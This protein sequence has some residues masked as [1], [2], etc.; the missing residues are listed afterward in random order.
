MQTENEK[1]TRRLASLL[2]LVGCFSDYSV[3]AAEDSPS[4]SS[5]ESNFLNPPESSKPKTR[6]HWINACISQ[7]GII[8]C[9]VR[10]QALL[11]KLPPLLVNG[12][13]QLK[14]WANPNQGEKNNHRHLMHL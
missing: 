3:S 4:S 13:G 7:Q 14:E 9:V 2:L 6:W 10:W 12:Q 1:I 11:A 5:L 8:A